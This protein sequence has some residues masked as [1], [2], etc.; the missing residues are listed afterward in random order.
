MFPPPQ[1][2]ETFPMVANLSKPFP[3]KIKEYNDEITRVL[4]NGVTKP[5]YYMPRQCDIIS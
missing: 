1:I 4:D 3:R 5:T 2:D